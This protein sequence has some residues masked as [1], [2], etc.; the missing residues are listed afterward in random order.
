MDLSPEEERSFLFEFFY[1]CL[2][3]RDDFS[4]LFL[5]FRRGKVVFFSF[6]KRLSDQLVSSFPS[7]ETRFFFL[8]RTR[9]GKL[10]PF[11]WYAS[12]SSCFLTPLLLPR[13]TEVR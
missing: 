10:L 9:G 1:R 11:L 12:R 8:L 5:N 4:S 2:A 7:S 6:P 13:I 3:T